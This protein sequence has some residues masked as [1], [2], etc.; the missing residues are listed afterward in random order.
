MSDPLPTGTGLSWSISPAKLGCAITSNTLN[1]S[2]GN[3]A[4]GTTHTVHVISPTT[5]ACQT[6][7]NTATVKVDGQSLGNASAT[8]G[9]RCL[10]P[11]T[12]GFWKN[13]RNQYNTTQFQTLVNYLKTHNPQVYSQLTIPIVDAIY[14]YGNATPRSQQVL[15]QLTAVKFNL[16]VTQLNGSGGIRQKND[17]ICLAGIVDVSWSPAATTFFGTATPTVGQVVAAFESRWTGTLTTNRANWT[18]NF[19][20][21]QMAMAIKILTGMNEGTYIL[22]SG[23]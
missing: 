17:N 7:N 22:T 12:I 18:F 19:T 9:T 14:N 15:G 13:W 23:C 5:R 10:H 4:G 3:V 2:F 20:E 11:G 6:Y 21:A 8:T 16:A 1:C